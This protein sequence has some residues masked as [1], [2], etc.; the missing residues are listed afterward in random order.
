MPTRKWG[1]EKL[2]NTTTTNAQLSPRVT[3]LSNGRII[4]V[5]QDF[6][7]G[8][9]AVRG[10]LFDATGVK[11][12]GE[13]AIDV[14]A[15]NDEVLPSVTALA[16]GGFYVTWTQLV[17]SS[18]YVLG[19]IYNADGAFVRSQPVVF[20]FYQDRGSVE[21]RLGTGTVVA[22]IHY[23]DAQT[24]DVDFR[25]FDAVGNGSQLFTAGHFLDTPV[26]LAIAVSPDH[27]N[28]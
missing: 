27:L 28:S 24:S 2:V 12:G 9:A 22:W 15:G 13:I 14:A 8:H 18:N 17:G 11:I 1:T 6:S 25:I 19:S 16:D 21:A 7:S 23:T 4:V 10:Q 5:W 20:A 26:D 3:V